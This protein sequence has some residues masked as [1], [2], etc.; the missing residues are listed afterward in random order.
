MLPVRY[1]SE[2]TF[3]LQEWEFQFPIIPLD[4]HENANGYGVVWERQW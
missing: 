1:L 2:Q 4:C 3:K